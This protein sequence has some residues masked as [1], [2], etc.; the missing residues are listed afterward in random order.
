MMSSTKAGQAGDGW[1]SRLGRQPTTTRAADMTTDPVRSGG[2]H[3]WTVG[4]V[5]GWSAFLFWVRQWC[6]ELLP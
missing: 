1:C 3:V 2:R 6:T 4:R 5:G